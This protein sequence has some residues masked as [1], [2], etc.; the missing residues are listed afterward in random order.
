[1]A[2]A[3]VY[4]DCVGDCDADG[5]VTLEEVEL[6]VTAALGQ[7]SVSTCRAQDRSGDGA[8]TVDELVAAVR[9]RLEGACDPS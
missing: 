8:I 4:T 9:S 5:T 3:I 7:A 1:M 2:N 6:G